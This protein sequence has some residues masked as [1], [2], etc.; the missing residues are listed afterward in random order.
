M[1]AFLMVSLRIR[2]FENDRLLEHEPGASFF[3]R[4]GGGV[5]PGPTLKEACP[6]GCT[7]NESMLD[8][9]PKEILRGGG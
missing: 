6:G 8:G 7:A 1:K 5:Q 9:R 3:L 4:P 2:M